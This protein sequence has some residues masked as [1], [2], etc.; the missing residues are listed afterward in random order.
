LVEDKGCRGI[1][2]GQEDKISFF[3]LCLGNMIEKIIL[4]ILRKCHD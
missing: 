1:V 3:A 2:D 4:A